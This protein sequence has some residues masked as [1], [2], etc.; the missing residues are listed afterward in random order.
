M[1]FKIKT[2]RQIK[3]WTW[4]A[5]ILPMS[6]LAAVFFIWRFYDGSTLS[7]VFITG[8]VLIFTVA[9]IWWWWAMYTMRNLVKHW[10]TTNVKVLEVLGE[11]KDMKTQV[12]QTFKLDDK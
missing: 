10:G 7:T 11:I 9:V 6:A 1:N 4:L 2:L 12:R 5:A 8:E 3:I